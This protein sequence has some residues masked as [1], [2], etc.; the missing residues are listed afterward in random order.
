DD[1]TFAKIIELVEEAQGSQA[2]AEKFLTKFATYYTPAMAL[3]SVL[4]YF[5]TR[6]AHIAI[7]FLVIACPGALVIGVPVST[8]SGIGNGAKNG[9]LIKGGEVMDNFSKV[10]M[11]VF[12]KTGPL[13]KGKPTVT[14]FKVFDDNPKE[15]LFTLVANA[16]RFSEHHLGKTIVQEAEKKALDLTYE[17]IDSEMIKGQGIKATVGNRRLT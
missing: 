8:V 5:L 15:T 3:L 10:D 9:V 13:K 12:D 14:D 16:E 7:T 2:T 1:T 17:V 4:V 6:D 11:G